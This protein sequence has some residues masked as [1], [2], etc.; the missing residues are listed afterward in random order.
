MA[1]P[2]Y[3]S[4]DRWRAAV[5]FLMGLGTNPELTTQDQKDLRKFLPG[6]YADGMTAI[7]AEKTLR[8]WMGWEHN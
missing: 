2:Y 3:V 7:E 1:N 6:R 4:I 5:K 8:D